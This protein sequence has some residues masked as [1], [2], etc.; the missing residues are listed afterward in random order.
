M[1]TIALKQFDDI[2]LKSLESFKLSG[3]PS[4][5]NEDY[6]YTNLAGKFNNENL[7][8]ET[9]T[10]GIKPEAIFSRLPFLE[11]ANRIILENGIC[12]VKEVFDNLM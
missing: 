5:K 6:K 9:I 7:L 2:R 3:I 8:A 12:C 10:I 4:S 1:C 11:D